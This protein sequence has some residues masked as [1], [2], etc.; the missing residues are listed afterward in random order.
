MLKFSTGGPSSSK[1]QVASLPVVDNNQCRQALSKFRTVIDDRVI[2]AGF[3]QGGTDACQGDSGGPYMYGK[4][5]S[6]SV[7][8]FLVGLVSYGYRCAEPGYPGVYTRISAFIDWIQNNLNWT[9]ANKKIWVRLINKCIYK[10]R[11]NGDCFL[12]T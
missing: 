6:R 5:E 7:R 3:P 4:P 2:C 12:N 8:F 1:L 9:T 11:K 10:L